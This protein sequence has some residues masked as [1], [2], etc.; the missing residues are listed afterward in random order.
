MKNVKTIKNG[1]TLDGKFEKPD[2][3]WYQISPTTEE[4]QK[5]SHIEFEVNSD[6]ILNISVYQDKEKS[7][8]R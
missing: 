4:V 8:K 5:F 3:Q 7:R 2:V 1:D 6:K